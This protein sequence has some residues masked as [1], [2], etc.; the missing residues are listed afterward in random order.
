VWV[1]R[2]VKTK[3]IPFFMVTSVRSGVLVVLVNVSRVKEIA[4]RV[5]RIDK[6][7]YLHDG[8]CIQRLLMVKH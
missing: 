5:F 8:E 7:I 1:V 4:M 6:V 2:D 3:V